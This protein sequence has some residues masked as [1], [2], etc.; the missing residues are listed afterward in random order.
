MTSQMDHRLSPL[1]RAFELADTGDYSGV[2]G[3][4]LTLAKEGYSVDQLYGPQLM[5][6]LRD[7]CQEARQRLDLA[8]S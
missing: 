2:A 3:I 8:G 5:R 7:R 6:Q 1:E 4:R